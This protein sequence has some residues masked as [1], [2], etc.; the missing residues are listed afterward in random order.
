MA[1][2]L[3]MIT[4]ALRRVGVAAPGETLSAD[5][6]NDALAVLNTMLDSWSTQRLSVYQ[7]LEED[8]LL[9]AN[10]GEYTIG[11]GGD[12]N[13]TRPVKIDDS[14]F[15]R[16]SNIDYPLE[17]IGVNA[18]N[19]QPFKS[20]SSTV[21]Y[22]LYCDY[23]YPLASIFLYPVPSVAGTLHLCSWKAL[24]SFSGLTTALSLP[25]GYRRA[26]EWNLAKELSPEYGRPVNGDILREAASS[27]KSIQ[28][29]NA[30]GK[31]LV[32]E[33]AYMRFRDISLNIYEG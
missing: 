8:F 3:D 1:T 30:P 18:Y 17:I 32:N 11:T 2:A 14:S 13:T 21:P 27:K 19:A 20:N 15:V 22:A 4:V 7:I 6:A 33:A 26:I 23:A 25:P 16:Y 10:D 5:Q 28:N 24:Q 29:I 31:T 12:F 9:T